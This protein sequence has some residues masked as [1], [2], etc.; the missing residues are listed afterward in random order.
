M[1]RLLF[2]LVLAASTAHAQSITWIKYDPSAIRT[3]RAAPATLDL[4]IAGAGVT[5]VRLDYA[6]GG[7][8]A[9]AQTTANRWSASVP[10]SQLLAGYDATDVNHNFVGFV[11]LLGGG[12]Q[13]LSTY[14]SFINVMDS[15]VPAPAI[16][17]FDATARA[18]P[19]RC[20]AS[21]SWAPWRWLTTV[22]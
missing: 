9:L 15:R 20:F 21:I 11:R 5:G 7:T 14:N 16:K 10:A 13:T 22:I 19:S 8:L 2:A 1:K 6:G 3:D 17:Q 12:G 18:M 4:L